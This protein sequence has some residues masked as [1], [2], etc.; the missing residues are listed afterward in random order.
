M[1]RQG[2]HQGQRDRHQGR[3]QPPRSIRDFWADYLRSGYFLEKNG[4]KFI[5]PDYVSYE[6]M[7][8]FARRLGEARL[9][10]SQLRRFFS[11]C[12]FIEYRLKGGTD[13]DSVR[14]D[15]V[16]MRYVATH[17][18]NR[19]S[20]EFPDIFYQFINYNVDTVKGK[21]DF[22]FGFMPHFEALVGYAST[23]LR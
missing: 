22:L 13:W 14:A 23:Y 4:T 9:S 17:A 11:H 10:K 2:H 6:K 5:N 12:R 3:N 16:K 7:D 21:E 18:K 1:N 20:S 8:D 19:A 15:F